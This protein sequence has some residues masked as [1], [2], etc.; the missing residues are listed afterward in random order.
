M[1]V[2]PPLYSYSTS[3]AAA[4]FFYSDMVVLCHSYFIIFSSILF[5]TPFLSISLLLFFSV[6]IYYY[7]SFPCST[8][9]RKFSSQLHTLWIYIYVRIDWMWKKYGNEKPAEE[10]KMVSER[11]SEWMNA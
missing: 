4:G 11:M 5:F 7:P 8:I 10:S 6:C 2:L 3:T 1:L 9:L